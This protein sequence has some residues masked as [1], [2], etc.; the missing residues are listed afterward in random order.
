MATSLLDLFNSSDKSSQIDT[1]KEKTPL[2]NKKV[3]NEGKLSDAR[4]G[5]INNTN[6]YSDNPPK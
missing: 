1:N 4:N 5:S 3:S 2:T 6:K